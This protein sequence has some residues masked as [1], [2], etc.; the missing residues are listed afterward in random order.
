MYCTV[1]Y[2]PVQSILEYN[3]RYMRVQCFVFES[4]VFN[5]TIH[6]IFDETQNT[7][8]SFKIT[9]NVNGILQNFYRIVLSFTYC[10]YCRKLWYS[11]FV[12]IFQNLLKYFQIF[13]KYLNIVLYTRNCS[14]LILLAKNVL[15][16]DGQLNKHIQKL[17]F[18]V[19]RF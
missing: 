6:K 15:T 10:I 9:D 11:C 12:K 8:S 2:F 18:F 14:N 4:H 19:L 13:L 1:Q 17:F 7:Y 5:N 3:T 16:F